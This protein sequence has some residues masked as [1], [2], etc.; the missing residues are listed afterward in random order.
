MS[1]R[2]LD[3]EANRLAQHLLAIEVVPG[4]V[5]AVAL[6][7]SFDLVVAF[8]GILKAGATYLPLDPGYP[9]ERREW[10]LSDARPVLVLEELP[11]VTGF[12]VSVPGVVVN[13]SG[14]AY[15]IYTSGSTGTPKGVV[16]SHAGAASLA[17]SQGERLGA[18]PGSRVLQFASPSFDA[19]FWELLLALGSGAAL[20]VAD[21][22]ESLEHG[23]GLAR[24]SI[25]S[26]AA[27][28]SIEASS[29]WSSATTWARRPS[30]VTAE[31]VS[32]APA[33]L[34]T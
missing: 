16:V 3:R 33:V 9:A 28:A 26:G 5:V 6:D 22:A 17:L 30:A 25:D 12:P 11:D 2:E 21:K 19:A 1:Y 23:A 34:P 18:G 15:V 29:R 31:A 14:A 20:V 13:A 24:Q 4:D 27:A 7:R 10:M 32:S 8:L